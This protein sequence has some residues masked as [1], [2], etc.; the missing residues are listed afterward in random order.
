MTEIPILEAHVSA[1]LNDAYPEVVCVASLLDGG[2]WQECSR[3]EAIPNEM[4]PDWARRLAIPYHF[5]VVQQLRFTIGDSHCDTTVHS[6]V[7]ARNGIVL[8]DLDRGGASSGSLTVQASPATTGSDHLLGRIRSEDLKRMHTFSR[9]RPY[10][11]VAS[12][13]ANGSE[14]PFHRTA[15]IPRVSG[16]TW[17]AF[18]APVSSLEAADI[19]VAVYDER[20]RESH[21][22]LIGSVRRPYREFAASPTAPVRISNGKRATGAVRLSL[23]LTGRPTFLDY[24][25]GRMQ[26]GFAAGLDF[27]A[28]SGTHLH[29][30][31]DEGANPYWQCLRAIGGLIEPY[32]REKE[33]PVLCSGVTKDREH[34]DHWPVSDDFGRMRVATIDGVLAEYRRFAHRITHGLFA[35]GR[36]QSR[37][38][39]AILRMATTEAKLQFEKRSAYFV[40]A[41]IA[42]GPLQDQ[43]AMIEAIAKAAQAPLSIV[44]VNVGEG[45]LQ[46]PG[47]EDAQQR[48]SVQIVRLADFACA[49]EMAATVLA[50]IPAQVTEYC[51]TAGVCPWQ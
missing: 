44:I 9:N 8:L 7:S 6:L 25:H 29:A 17:P 35:L 30:D 5:G 16:C 14:V 27:S 13:G 45:D 21:S 33:Y 41:L 50:Q 11:I 15:V 40:V 1:L 4:L 26:L 19:S 32:D 31:P 51:E 46:L 18:I 42:H 2:S 34:S 22:A 37:K 23:R 38:F 36:S 24:L 47:V 43:K 39:A 10:A 28:E 48:K 3:T 12:I 20:E 49:E